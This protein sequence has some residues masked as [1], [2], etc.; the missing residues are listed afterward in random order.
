MHLAQHHFQAQTA[1]FEELAGATLS[2]LFP[3]PYG[4][5]S[6]QLDD[7]ALL[8][9]TAAVVAARGIMPDGVPFSFPEDALPEPLRIMDIFSPTQS[10]HVLMLALPQVTPGRANVANG[11]LARTTRFSA[12]QRSVPDETTGS[13]ERP[14]QLARKNFRLL[15]DTEP[16][17]GLVTLPIARVQ[18]DGAGHFVF[19]YSFIGP[20]LRIAASRRLR[21]LVA[22]MLD[23]LESRSDAVVAERGGS[24]ASA[25][26]APREIASFWFLHALNATTP[27]LR[28]W[29]STGGAHPEQLYLQLVQLAGALCTFSLTSHPRDLPTYDHDAPEQCFN[30]LERHIRQHLD[31]I[32]PAAAI[33]LVLR[34][35]EESFYTAGV[36]DARCFD[37]TA[38]W[39]LG[40]RSS[41]PAGDVIARTGRL[42]KV[43]SAKF[44]ARLVREAY[45]GLSMDHVPVPPPEL[46]PR[47]GTHYF[48]IRRSEPCWKSIVDSQEVGLYVPGAIPDPELELKVVLQRRG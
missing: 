18:R 21:E 20:C 36:G 42:V 29:L 19:D 34:P 13:D 10:S 39:F 16:T 1:Y 45:P 6:L 41:A 27:A 12:V 46:S 43:C 14:V 44:I 48:A 38:S 2:S 35:A 8:N 24:R 9:G 3:A 15:L 37:P 47:I 30:T 23:M 28:H 26:Y 33:S 11:D 31:V 17:T 4:V 25:E 22:R 5:V 40:V 7:E 32:F